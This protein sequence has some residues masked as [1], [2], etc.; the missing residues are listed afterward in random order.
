MSAALKYDL[1]RQM[2]AKRRSLTPLQLHQ[3]EIGL[4]QHLRALPETRRA[5][6]IGLYWPIKGEISLLGLLQ[7]PWSHR[8]KFYLP[9]L[10]PHRRGLR[11]A[12]YVRGETLRRNRL[13]I[14]E[15]MVSRRLWRSARQLDLLFV[16]LLAFD[17]KGRRLGMGGGFYD[18]T[19]AGLRH[20]KHWLRPRLLGVAHAFQEVTQ[21]PAEPWDVPLHGICTEQGY[22]SFLP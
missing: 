9:V 14:P 12:P 11:F 16:P 7:Q 1:R 5:R 13:G 8:Q 21:L 4:L 18:R 19:L 6:E 17:G 15:P 10:A 3:A 20:R 2:R 22:R